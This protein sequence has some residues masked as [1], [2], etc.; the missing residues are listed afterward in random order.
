MRRN[1][2][3]KQLSGA[4]KASFVKNATTTRSVGASSRLLEG[5]SGNLPA[6][7]SVP[8]GKTRLLDVKARSDVVAMPT[9]IPWLEAMP[10]LMTGRVTCGSLVRRSLYLYLP[11]V[12]RL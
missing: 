8:A 11:D 6:H 2:T 3:E 10:P 9:V 7:G 1:P 4:A 5:D 12:C